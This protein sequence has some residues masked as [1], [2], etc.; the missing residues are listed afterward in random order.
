VFDAWTEQFSMQRWRDA[1]SAEG[2]DLEATVTAEHDPSDALAWEHIS[3]GV[4]RGFLLKERDRALLGETTKDCSA[5]TCTGCGV[6][7]DLG[8]DIVLGGTSRA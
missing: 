5:D 4:D 3:S 6:C 7:G 1:F 8:V 2:I